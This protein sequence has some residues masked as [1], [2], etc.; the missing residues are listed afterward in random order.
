[1]TPEPYLDAL[2][3]KADAFGELLAVSRGQDALI[4]QDDAEALLSLLGRKKEIIQRIETID[5]DLA[6][7]RAG[8]EARA[9][10]VS[11]DQAEAQL[12]RIRRTL[13]DLMACEEET[14]RRAER[15]KQSTLDEMTKIRQ[16]RRAAQLY[17]RTPP[18]GGGGEGFQG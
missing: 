16:G 2:T 4:D 13:E 15:L 18:G 17:R 7:A 1:M 5:R 11:R 8:W 6:A 14:K 3:R 9:R 12:A 10:S